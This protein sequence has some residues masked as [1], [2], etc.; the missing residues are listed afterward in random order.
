MATLSLPGLTIGLPIWLFSTS[1]VQNPIFPEQSNQ[2][3]ND[4]RVSSQPSTSSDSPSPP[5]SSLD[6]A[7]KAKNQVT[8]KKKKQKEKKEKKKKEPKSK[9]GNQASSSENPHTA[10]SKPK[11]PCVICNGDHYHRDC[12]C[13]P[14]ILRDWSPR[15]HNPIAL[16][17]GDHVECSPS[18]SESEAHGQ[19][20]NPKLPCKLC[21]GS[22][23]VHRCPFLDEAKRV[24][25]DRP[26][27][28]LRLPPGY[29]KLLPSPPP[30]ENLAGLS[31]WSAEASIIENEPSESIPDESQKVETAVDPVLPSECSSSKDTITEEKE[32]DTVQILFVNTESDELGGSLPIPL[33]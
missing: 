22:H 17:S 27:S 7:D 3:L 24:L 15:L 9:G 33:S 29:K 21:E 23:A 12:P 30:V 25:D 11:S 16:T 8:E 14:R 6:K 19:R 28:P 31:L 13:I 10:P 5:S 26:V 1:V 4:T 32:N 2:Q 18:T 20:R